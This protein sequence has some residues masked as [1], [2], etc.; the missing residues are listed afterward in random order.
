VF[1]SVPLLFVL[2]SATSF[3]FSPTSSR[4]LFVKF[5]AATTK[6]LQRTVRGWNENEE[7]K[8]IGKEVGMEGMEGGIASYLRVA[9]SAKALA[10]WLC[11]VFWGVLTLTHR[12]GLPH[13]LSAI[14][15]AATT[16]NFRRLSMLLFVFE[17]F[18][19]FFCFL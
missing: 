11:A 13:K 19:Y 2:P 10:V 1:T 12:L 8:E 16:E 17:Y 3:E 6:C 18:S 7:L 5:G 4:E 15:N 14:F 9:A